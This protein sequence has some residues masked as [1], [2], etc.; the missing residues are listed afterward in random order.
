[1]PTINQMVRKGRKT[2]KAKSKAPAL[3]YTLNSYKQRRFRQDNLP[4]YSV[5]AI[6]LERLNHLRAKWSE[7]PEAVRRKGSMPVSLMNAMVRVNSLYNRLFVAKPEPL[8]ES[9]AGDEEQ[10]EPPGVTGDSV[11]DDA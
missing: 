4:M 2:K 8:Q 1:M 3:Q 7:Q 10:I 6:A 11:Q 5:N 9:E